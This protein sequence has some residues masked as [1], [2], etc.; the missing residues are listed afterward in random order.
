MSTTW[1]IDQSHSDV[2]FKVKHLM[3]STVTGKF[4]SYDG[5]VLQNNSDDS[6]DGSSISFTADVSSISTGVADRDN[7]LRS[8]DFFNA[9]QFPKMTF[10]ASSFEKVSDDEYTL[11]GNL[12]IRDNTKPVS[13]RATFNGITSD[14]WGGTRAGF[15]IT[16]TIKRKEFGLLWNATTEL[17]GVVVSDDVKLALDIQLV[18]Q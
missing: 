18:K 2:N 1:K 10:E 6:F 9:E 12:T 4:E 16:G 13:L 8:N 3:I 17:G 5:T 11:N 7:H 14:M 15:E